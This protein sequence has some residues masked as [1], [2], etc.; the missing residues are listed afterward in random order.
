QIMKDGLMMSNAGM[1]SV[2]SEWNRGRLESYLIKITSDILGYKDA[3]GGDLI[4][5]IL[6]TAGQKGT[7]K[8][9][10]IA[11][12]D[13]G[14]PLTL[15]CEAVFARS[16][17]A[18][19]EGRVKASGLLECGTEKQPVEI[20]DLES[21]LYAAKLVSYAQGYSLMR[22]AAKTYVWNLNYG[23]I[24]LMWRGG[25]IIRSAFLGKIRDAFAADPELENLL[26]SPFFREEMLSCEKSLRRVVSAA[27][28]SG[29]PVPALSSALAYF[30]G[31]RCGRLPANLLQA[32]RDYFGAHTYERV[33]AP[34][35]EHFHTDW[36]NAGGATAS[37]FYNA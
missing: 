22:A 7:G 2:F 26:L 4:D 14:V 16:L 20:A 9:A 19:K 8:W 1:K 34:R 15:I 5:S 35:G 36:T 28:M 13:E 12:L 3:G 6:D 30:D 23:G 32:M 27:V 25:C 29:I 21:A 24:A 37:T 11:A 10:S 18:D 31:L 17:S 33:D